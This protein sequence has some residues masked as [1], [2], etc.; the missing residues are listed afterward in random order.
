MLEKE[1][2]ILRTRAEASLGE[3]YAD[4]ARDLYERICTSGHAL[5]GDHYV[6]ANLLHRQGDA[7]RTRLSLEK[8]VAAEPAFAEAWHMLGALNG[9]QGRPELAVECFR[10][11][12]TIHPNATEA[13]LNLAQALL[14]AGQWEA[15]AAECN[16]VI[17]ENAGTAAAWTMLGR[18]QAERGLHDAA[19]DSFRKALAL[20][21]DLPQALMGLGFALHQLGHWEEASGYFRSA[22]RC[23]PQLMPGHFGLGSSLL[24][25]GNLQEALLHLQEAVNLKPEHAEAQLGVGTVLSLMGNQ[26]AAVASIREALR[27]KPD[28]FNAYVT[29]AATLMTL[30]EPEEAARLCEQALALEPGNI[31]AISLATT[32]DQHM[33]NIERARARLKPLIDAGTTEVNVALAYGAICSSLD[34]PGAGIAVM[35]RLLEQNH[36]ITATGKRNLH[37]NLGKLYDKQKSYSKAFEH[38]R[39][40][41]AIKEVQFDP[42]AQ[43]AETNAIIAIHTRKLLDVLPRATR[44]SDRPVFVVGM[45]RSGTS[46]VEQILASHPDVFGAGELPDVIELARSLGGTTATGQGYPHYMP[47]LTQQLIDDTARRYLDHLDALAATAVRVVDKMPGNFIFLGL[48]ELLFPDARIIH[49]KRDPLDTCLSCYFQDFS[50]SHPYSYD[51]ARLGVF[52][53]NYERLM[54]H[55]RD[56]I[57]LPILEVQ[58]EDLIADQEAGSLRIVEFCD[59]PWNDRCL[60][61]HQTQRYVA[62]ASYDQVRRPIYKSSV[63]RWKNYAEFIGP[64]RAALGMQD[65]AGQ[66]AGLS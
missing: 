38:Y 2:L 19:V 12:L 8:A 46:L 54:R 29:L 66:S 11:V 23:D 37:F 42:E 45:P 28:L 24:K 50:R 3:G 55:W 49:C 6:L 40:G 32:I 63:Q 36:L 48:I 44:R 64:L 33:G 53:R 1:I 17:G 9:M 7:E 26:R 16:G 10:K 43:T 35:E 52:Y 34:D 61:F 65:G 62:T 58:Y 15:A 18:S 41:N 22:L 56:V 31:E 14:Q 30:A 47:E 20:Q 13:R 57:R 51:L 59:L 39:L 21:P 27:L 25:L 4:E 60:Q 5:A